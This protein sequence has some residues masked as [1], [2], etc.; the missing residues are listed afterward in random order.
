MILLQRESR[1][2]PAFIKKPLESIRFQ[3]LFCF[4]ILSDEPEE[5]KSRQ[6]DDLPARDSSDGV[7]AMLNTQI[8]M[9]YDVPSD[10]VS[11][12]KF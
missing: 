6:D 11:A 3:G 2:L 4:P 12:I 8:A 7:L 10:D 1:S 9:A 5:R